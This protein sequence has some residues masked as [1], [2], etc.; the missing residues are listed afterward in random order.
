MISTFLDFTTIENRDRKRIFPV[1]KN[2]GK[3]LIYFVNNKNWNKNPD[4]WHSSLMTAGITVLV[5]PSSLQWY[6][7]GCSTLAHWVRLSPGH[8]SSQARWREKSWLCCVCWWPPPPPPL[9]ASTGGWGRGTPSVTANRIIRSVECM[10]LNYS[11][12][13]GSFFWDKF[14]CLMKGFRENVASLGDIWCFLGWFSGNVA[15]RQTE[16]TLIKYGAWQSWDLISK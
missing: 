3:I 8:Q 15:L 12:G 13:V 5:C 9:T 10:S 11:L 1:W 4:W 16:Q 6:F 14:V 7:P 2:F